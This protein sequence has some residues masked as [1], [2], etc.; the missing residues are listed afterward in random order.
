[1]RR[2]KATDQ[3]TEVK[4]WVFSFDFKEA[5]EDECLTEGGR[6][7]QTTGPVY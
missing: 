1:M 6:E 4:R 2:K 7:F 3:Y 5:I